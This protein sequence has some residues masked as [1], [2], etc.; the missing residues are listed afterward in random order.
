MGKREEKETWDNMGGLDL[1]MTMNQLNF[2]KTLNFLHLG[3]EKSYAFPNHIKPKT[4]Q[5]VVSF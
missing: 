1:K 3:K 2:S 5:A 4:S